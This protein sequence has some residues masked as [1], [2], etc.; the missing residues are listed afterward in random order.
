MEYV[1]GGELF[2]RIDLY[3]GLREPQCC[4]IF[5][6]ICDSVRYIH[7]KNFIHGDIKPEN[8]I[9]SDLNMRSVK[10]VDFGAAR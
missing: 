8:I 6:Q 3:D 1:R 9:F 5:T 2:Q 4:D 7:R 10:I